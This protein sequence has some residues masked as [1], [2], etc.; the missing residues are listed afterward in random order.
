MT[1]V[2]PSLA[3]NMASD[4]YTV[5]QDSAQLFL[6][7]PEFLKKVE[8]K[9][10]L[11]ATVGSR[12]INTRDAFGVCALGAGSYQNDIF[13][14]FRGS[15]SANYYADW[16]NNARVGVERSETGAL[17]HLGFNHI[18]L[19]MLAQLREFIDA[20][21]TVTGT[22]H[23]IGHS[24][25]GAVATLAA[26][27]VKSNRLNPVKLYTFG[28]PRVSFEG[29]AQQVTRKLSAS[30]IF[31]V[32]HHSDPV[33]MIPIFPFIH[34][35]SPGEGYRIDF[36]SGLMSVEAHGMAHYIRSTRDKP[37]LALQA[38]SRAQYSDGDLEQWLKSDA[39]VNSAN[40]GIWERINDALV[41]VL[42]KL[43]VAA[44]AP[45]QV[46]MTGALT[47]ADRIA[48]LLREAIDFS[49]DVG[50][51]VLRLMR[52]IMQALGMN[53]AGTTEQ[54]TRQLMGWVLSQL[55]NRMAEHAQRA[56][57]NSDRR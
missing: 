38:G 6:M 52:R 29:F 39:P 36:G 44:L 46:A 33:P 51:W 4:I 40:P 3:A 5:Q 12:L 48:Y 54:L 37:W 32:Y 7:R 25:G 47:I 53:V 14:I 16:I 55:S 34:A 49:A 8:G 10:P 24:L 57:R 41:W 13:L 19:S 30:N 35:P 23:C 28:A 2:S 31:R 17:V 22:I 15:T 9:R 27:W 18:F 42:K 20:N 11:Q 21:P 26:D 56:V 45:L 43:T 50:F 1:L